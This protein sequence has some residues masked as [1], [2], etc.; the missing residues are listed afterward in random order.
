MA[1][2]FSLDHVL[3]VSEK[4]RTILPG[5]S[6]SVTPDDDPIHLLRNQAG[7]TA[8]RGSEHDVTIRLSNL[9]LRITTTSKVAV[10]PSTT[11]ILARELIGPGRLASNTSSAC[12][13]V[14]VSSIRGAFFDP[15]NLD[16]E[17]EVS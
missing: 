3:S 17:L 15:A 5:M 11:T 13:R 4:T 9:E 1:V 8:S 6:V 12:C 16:L 7:T 10:A 14:I 2:A